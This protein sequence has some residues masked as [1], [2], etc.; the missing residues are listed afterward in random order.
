M[1]NN[2][3]GLV[4]IVKAAG[5]SWQG[6]RAA[7]QNEAAFRQEAVAALVA[8]LVACW[9]DVD[10]LSRIL[11]IGSVVLVIIVEILNS[12]IEAV[13]DRIGQ[14]QHPLAGRA[15]DMGSAAVLLTILLALFVWIALLWTHLR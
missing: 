2:V 9:L 4:R 7:W 5:Y 8:I 14:E 12:A 1:A 6:L 11:M 10:T 3:T 15:K 13:V